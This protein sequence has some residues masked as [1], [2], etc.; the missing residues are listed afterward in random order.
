MDSR[1][2]ELPGRIYSCNLHYRTR[3]TITMHVP[4]YV[5]RSVPIDIELLFHSLFRFKTEWRIYYFFSGFVL[6]ARYTDFTSVRRTLHLHQVMAWHLTRI[7]L[8]ASTDNQHL[9]I[10]TP[11][12]IF[13]IYIYVINATESLDYDDNWQQQQQISWKI[14]TSASEKCSPFWSSRIAYQTLWNTGRLRHSK[15]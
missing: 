5:V 14:T 11:Y 6:W 2:I 8:L 10:Y 4:L 1:W 12:N 3:E 15:W 13:I 9:I 7:G